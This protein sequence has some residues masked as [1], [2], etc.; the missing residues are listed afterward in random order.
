LQESTIDAGPK[1]T[2]A[3]TAPDVQVLTG[4]MASGDE[5]AYRTFHEAYFQRLYRYLLVVAA[6]DEDAAREAVQSTF[7]RVVRYIKPFDEE[8]RFWN[9]LAVLARTALA[10][11][12]RKGGRYRAF[13]ERFIGH[14]RTE[15]QITPGSDGQADAQLLA[16][17]EERV[18][19]L[20]AD[21]RDLVQRKYFARDSVRDI[22]AS[23]QITEK[24]VESRLTRV[25]LKLKSEVLSGLKHEARTDKER[26]LADVLNPETNSDFSADV[27]A[28][29]LRGVRRQR[30]VRQVRRYG[31]ALA[32]L[33]ALSLVSSHFVRSGAKPKLVQLPKSTGYQLVATQPL[34][35][36]QITGTQLLSPDQ[37]IVSMA[38]V[39]LVQTTT[40]GFGEIGDDELI[41]LAAPNVVALVRRG[42]HEAELVFVSSPPEDSSAQQN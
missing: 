21:E 3:V 24:A 25:R 5:N 33:V 19:R 8:T 41:S 28:E 11:Q 4:D 13:L 18:R 22:A 31:A 37:Q 32:L 17:L 30:R 7:L 12:R 23:L 20:P 40:G 10:D 36:G 2:A 9:W 39:A 38:R 35:S 16:A 6:G 29:T 1:E 14:A 26:L 27:L 34:A 15:T 42:P